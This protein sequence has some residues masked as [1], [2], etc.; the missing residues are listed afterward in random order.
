M[1][2]L[3][4]KQ[5]FERY[6]TDIKIT[7]EQRNHLELWN[8]KLD[9][10]ELIAET[11]NYHYF[12]KVFLN[13]L[14]G[15]DSFTDILADDKE[16]TGSGKSA[17]NPPGRGPRPSQRTRPPPASEARL[18]PAS[19]NPPDTDFPRGWKNSGKAN[20]RSWSA[21]AGGAASISAR[22]P[23]KSPH[24][25]MRP[26]PRFRCRTSTAARKRT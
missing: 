25:H 4:N 10:G 24:S 2:N 9:A 20:R 12:E 16:E 6:L 13:V 19:P 5:L 11:S 26:G 3:F 7:E 1:N 14:F 21:P 8:S 23:S 15:Y 17:R 22:R 18:Q